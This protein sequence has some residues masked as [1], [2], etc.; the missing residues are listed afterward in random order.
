MALQTTIY[1]CMVIVCCSCA[2]KIFQNKAQHTQHT[3]ITITFLNLLHL[4]LGVLLCNPNN[5]DV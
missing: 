1:V 5:R 4:L 3:V 2:K